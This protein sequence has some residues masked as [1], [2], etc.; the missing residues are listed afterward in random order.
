MEI[1]HLAKVFYEEA[2]A[3]SMLPFASNA[4][5]TAMKMFG[6]HFMHLAVIIATLGATLGLLFNWFLGKLLQNL[7]TKSKLH[8]SPEH[9]S[10]AVTIFNKYGI[11]LLLLSWLPLM[12]IVLIF[13]GFL[14]T[15]LKVALPLAAF[16]QFAYYLLQ[17][18]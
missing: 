11:F 10:Q 3:N 12:K 8:L 15:R 18:A 4:T 5:F 9:Y 16:G 1:E 13:A 6:G 14:N 7:H 17:I 2:W